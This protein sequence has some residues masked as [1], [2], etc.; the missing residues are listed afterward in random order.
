LVII[1]PHRRHAEFGELA[2]IISIRHPSPAGAMR[3]NHNR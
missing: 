1:K 3:I 2:Q